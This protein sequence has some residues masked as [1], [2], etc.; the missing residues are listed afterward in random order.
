MKKNVFASRLITGILVMM[1]VAGCDKSGTETDQFA[2]GSVSETVEKDFFA[3]YP[4]CANVKDATFNEYDN[5]TVIHFTDL[6]GLACTAIYSGTTWM[7]TQ[8]E[9]DKD[10]F[11]FLGQLP[12]K[13][14]RAYIRVGIDGED[15]TTIQG[16]YVVEISRRGIGKSQYEFHFFEHLSGT[17]NTV[18]EHDILL[19]G[20][21]ELLDDS[22][23]DVNRSIW[24]PDMDGC[25]DYVNSRYPSAEILGALNKAGYD[26]LFI[27][28]GDRRKTVRFDHRDRVNQNWVETVWQL[29]DDAVLPDSVAEGYAEYRKENPEFVYSSVYFVERKDGAYY[30]LKMVTDRLTGTTVYF[31]V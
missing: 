7:I 4:D 6:D 25:I 20:D 1:F 12:W 24:W 27:N 3:R 22:Y 9:Y 8:K 13:I 29:D 28:D 19:G 30:G 18:L 2:L 14:A 16:A 15:Y 5:Q 10:D 21:G 31:K 17:D 23:G 11:A 26:V